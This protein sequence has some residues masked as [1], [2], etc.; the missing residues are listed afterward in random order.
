MKKKK[1]SK[2]AN[3]T[4]V[5]SAIVEYLSE[6][7]V[8]NLVKYV[9]LRLQMVFNITYDENRGIN[10]K[11]IEDLICE[12]TMS[13][14]E[15][16]RRYWYIDKYPDFNDQYKSALNSV[17]SNEVDKLCRKPEEVRLEKVASFKAEVDTD[18]DETW[19][20]LQK[21]LYKLGADDDEILYFEAAY[22]CGLKRFQI[23]TELGMSERAVTDIK[24]RLDRRLRQ[25][26]Q[27]WAP[28]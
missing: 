22:I 8:N 14:L 28:N 17:I 7:Q 9:I 10:G 16:G 13:F 6:A 21:E 5:E 2:I 27:Y 11:N 3:Q 25:L 26:R 15:E 18:F 12:T 1:S 24:R 19:E 23:A 20:L 4:E